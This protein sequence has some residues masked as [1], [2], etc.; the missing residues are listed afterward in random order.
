MID[1]IRLTE[2]RQAR[3]V[4]EKAIDDLDDS[5]D[6]KVEMYRKLVVVNN[7]IIAIAEA[8]LEAARAEHRGL[9]AARAFNR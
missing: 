9:T 7:D 3:E 4:L 2:L 1:E 6:R 8:N 5:D